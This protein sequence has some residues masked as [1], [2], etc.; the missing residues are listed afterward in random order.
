MPRILGIDSSLTGTG[1]CRLDITS[2]DADGYVP[3]IALATVRVSKSQKGDTWRAKSRRVHEALDQ[4]ESAITD[5]IERPDRDELPDLVVLEELAYG[6]KG[7]ALVVLHWLWGEV[8]TLCCRYDV[9]LLL[10][11]VAGIKKF[12]TGKGNAP[13]EEVL[14]AMVHRY[15]DAGIED[16]NQ[17]DAYAA[18]MMGARW[19]NHPVDRM[20]A[21]H[22]EAMNKVALQ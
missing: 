3:E 12:A 4:I 16:N 15:P 8:V 10:V 14:L 9:P 13:K 17:A 19:M 5:G 20:P 6:A 7:T 11:N 22:L 21:L 1:L 2:Y 18:A